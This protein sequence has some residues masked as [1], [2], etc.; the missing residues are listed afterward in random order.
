MPILGNSVVLSLDSLLKSLD[1]YL[2]LFNVLFECFDI[3]VNHLRLAS[4]SSRLLRNRSA[5]DNGL[6]FFLLSFFLAM[7]HLCRNI[8][9][10]ANRSNRP[11]ICTR[12]RL[13]IRSEWDDWTIRT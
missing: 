12:S 13:I 2:A 3:V 5:S 11:V 4:R 1:V 6:T 9:D 8:V 10:S 7:Y